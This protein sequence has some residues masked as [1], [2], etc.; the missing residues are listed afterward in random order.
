MNKVT[1][2][3][4]LNLHELMIKIDIDIMIRF[5]LNFCYSYLRVD[6]Q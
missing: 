2:K 6:L 4:G 5:I 1:L 3:C